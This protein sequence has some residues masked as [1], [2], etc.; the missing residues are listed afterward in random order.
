MNKVHL[1][2]VSWPKEQKPCLNKEDRNRIN[3]KYLAKG[4]WKPDYYT[5]MLA[6]PPNCCHK[7]GS[8][9]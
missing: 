4:L 9:V 8:T 2:E 1:L 6:F 7:V 3:Y 5:H